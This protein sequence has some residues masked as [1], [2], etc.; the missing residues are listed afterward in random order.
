LDGGSA[1]IGKGEMKGNKRLLLV[2]A[3]AAFAAFAVP[4]TASA[5]VWKDGS[6]NVSKFVEIGLT[7]AEVF[8][9]SEGNGMG[10]EVHA[11]LTTEG[12]STGK[13]TKYETKSCS[14]KFGS[15]SKCEV[16][17][18]EA[19]G[20]PW[21]VDVNTS[22]LTITGWHI[23]RLFKAGCGTTELNK[24]VG[25]VTVTLNT[26][27]SITGMEFL[28]EITGYKTFGSFTVDAPNS[29]TYGIG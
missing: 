4:A 21:T 20:L 28:G 8:E 11:T 2:G 1:V 13:I 7:G 29:G 12:G 5:S 17:S 24:T 15:F 19:R 18:S 9:T 25:S 3:I 6:T 16:S 10:C 22:N 14:L 26:P 27:S 23:K